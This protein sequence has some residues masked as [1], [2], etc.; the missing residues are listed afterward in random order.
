M[1]TRTLDILSLAKELHADAKGEA[2][3]RAAISRAYYAGLHAA[4]A[5]FEARERIGAESSHMQII[6]SASAYGKGVNPGR[7]AAAQIAQALGRM[8]RHRNQADYH[9]DTT[10]EHSDSDDVIK[11]AEAVLAWCE[12]VVRKRAEAKGLDA[13][14]SSAEGR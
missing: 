7:S 12:E 14:A 4:A 13:T 9:L 6:G 11:R 8:R 2:A 1:P 5:T 10:L 3:I